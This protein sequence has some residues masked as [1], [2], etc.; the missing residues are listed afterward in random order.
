MQNPLAPDEAHSRPTREHYYPIL[1][2]ALA[3]LDDN[4]A[5]ARRKVYERARAM[6]AEQVRGMD[7]PLPPS[8]IARHRLALEL[9]IQ[10]HEIEEMTRLR[11]PARR[12]FETF[13][14]PASARLSQTSRDR[15]TNTRLPLQP[16]CGPDSRQ[17][18]AL[19][20]LRNLV[21]LP[22][23]PPYELPQPNV[24]PGWHEQT[25]QSGLAPDEG[26]PS[27]Q[28]VAAAVASTR[29]G[30][31]WFGRL[32]RAALL[33]SAVAGLVV[34]GDWPAERM[35]AWLVGLLVG[36]N[37]LTAH[38]G[39]MQFDLVDTANAVPGEAARATT[40]AEEPAHATAESG[41]APVVLFEDGP[42]LTGGRPIS[43][44]VTWRSETIVS[45]LWGGPERAVRA[46][47]DI[48]G[49]G[50]LTVLL[51]RNFDQGFP[52]SHAIVITTS[53]GTEGVGIK[54]IPG[55]LMKRSGEPRG[56]PLRG[57]PMTAEAGQFQILLSASGVDIERN[58]QM[59][60]ER[61][62]LGIP[63]IYNDGRRSML[64]IEKGEQGDRAFEEAFAQWG[65]TTP[66]DAP[67]S[68]L[69]V[70]GNL[71]AG[72]RPATPG[73]PWDPTGTKKGDGKRSSSCGL[74]ARPCTRHPPAGAKLV[75]RTGAVAQSNPWF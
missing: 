17:E 5:A 59:L 65:H 48:P 74:N 9:A 44:S 47:V 26:L 33:T 46:D 57:V 42:D 58:E 75:T 30:R 22:P 6:I 23:E 50:T 64:T 7:P 11:T 32:R 3:R 4:T 37:P 21:E 67:N 25:Y 19:A 68:L 18:R 14:A 51:R 8:L 29:A 45:P 34:I 66:I 28:H 43:G 61:P 53:F 70:P 31:T 69:S 24:E 54:E 35:G 12:G 1:A 56:S 41:L 52:A 2:A 49:K 36:T 27:I 73:R 60:R 55:V 72:G 13:A 71:P 16:A 39:L 10:Q 62:M 15:N 63:I 20:S 38:S 40:M